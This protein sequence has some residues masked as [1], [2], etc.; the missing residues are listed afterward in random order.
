[1]P[2]LMV[3]SQEIPSATVPVRWCVT[4]DEVEALKKAEA[5]NPHIL[6]VVMSGSR[7]TR[8]LLPLNQMMEYLQFFKPGP[9]QVFASIVWYCTGKAG[10]LQDLYLARKDDRYR[11]TVL[12]GEH[13][14]LLE[15]QYL[16]YKHLGFDRLE[17]VLPS[18]LFAKEPPQWEQRWVNLWFE[19]K[20]RDEC[21]Y[22]RRRILAYTIQPPAVLLWLTGLLGWRWLAAAFQL[23]LLCRRGVNLKPL[24]HPWRYKTEDI[25]DRAGETIFWREVGRRGEELPL[26]FLLPFAPIWP[27]VI[28]LGLGLLYLRNPALLIWEIAAIIFGCSVG[29]MVLGTVLLFV[30]PALLRKLEEKQKAKWR[31][32]QA[33]Y[34]E[35]LCNGCSEVSFRALPPERQTIYLRFQDLK[36]RVCQPFAR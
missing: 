25:W 4:K 12:N 29:L 17:L 30:S 35:L 9:S 19:T 5:L 18:E 21:Q 22:R 34:E 11:N 23:L 10:K 32:A 7:E 16:G 3:E 15:P 24:V 31:K 6:L 27:L 2:K 14:G 20:P 28:L 8:Y 33:D 1:M 13:D 36:A 26:L